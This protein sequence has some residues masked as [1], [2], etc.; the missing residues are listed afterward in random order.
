MATSTLPDRLLPVLKECGLEVSGVLCDDVKSAAK[1]LGVELTGV[2]P[3]DISALRM[4]AGIDVPEPPKVVSLGATPDL[5]E[6]PPR[7]R[8]RREG[9]PSL[10]KNG[11]PR[12][13]RTTQ[14]PWEKILEVPL[15]T[16][17]IHRTGVKHSGELHPE[18]ARLVDDLS[19]DSRMDN[20]MPYVPKTAEHE[21]QCIKLVKK[22]KH[23]KV[24]VG[25]KDRDQI[26][27]AELR[28]VHPLDPDDNSTLQLYKRN[29][30]HAHHSH[31][32]T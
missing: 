13:R 18:A 27:R 20:Q 15:G 29:F 3:A 6:A 32:D 17:R 21:V 23:R 5:E 12:K 19:G 4:S 8:S 16:F 11:E 31:R 2:F 1:N 28:L 25:Q 7:K 30:P 10:R 24:T 22:C 26:C 14:P 9:P